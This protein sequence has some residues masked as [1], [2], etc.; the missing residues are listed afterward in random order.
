[1]SEITM[2]IPALTED[3]AQRQWDSLNT[4]SEWARHMLVGRHVEIESVVDDGQP[5]TVIKVD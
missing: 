1:M 2:D 5:Y 3:E 4:F